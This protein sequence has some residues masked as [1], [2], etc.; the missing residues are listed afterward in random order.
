MKQQG[1]DTIVNAAWDARASTQPLLR[2][3]LVV[4]AG[5]AFIALSARIQVP[6]WPVPMTM[7]TFAVLL[8]A[9]AFGARLAVVTVAAYLAQG[10]MGLPVFAGGG[11]LPY[12]VG[13]TA[14]YLYAFLAVALVVGHL[15]DRG[16]GRGVARAFA[17]TLAGSV[18][19][20]AIG[21]SWLAGYVGAEQA[22]ALGVAPFVIGDLLKAALAA[23]LLPV[24]WKLLRAAQ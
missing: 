16:W 12:L 3:I 7:Q 11:G 22:V 14:G 19:I 4:L 1:T 15:G 10:V 21:A 23:L 9:L 5:S 24:A 8:V 17:A 13:P 20:Y 2:A 18:L 6:M